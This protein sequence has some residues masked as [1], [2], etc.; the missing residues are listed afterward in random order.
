M[1]ETSADE[2][3]GERMTTWIAFWAQFAV[4]GICAVVGAYFAGQGGGPGDYQS[5]LCLFIGAVIFAFMRLK[6]WFDGRGND[7]WG[8]LFV[9]RMQ[10]LWVVVPLFAIIGLAGLFIAAGFDYGSLHTAGLALFVVSG[11][12]IFLSLKRVFDRLDSHE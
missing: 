8:F 10:T 1:N 5:G 9:D 3:S 2:T 7:W 11:L 6:A 12:I 4:L